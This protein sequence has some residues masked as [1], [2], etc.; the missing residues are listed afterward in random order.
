VPDRAA[1]VDDEGNGTGLKLTDDLKAPAVPEG[2]V[3]D[4]HIR[5]EPRQ[6]VRC[7]PA[8]G[9]RSCNIVPAGVERI[10]EIKPNEGTILNE[11]TEYRP[12]QSLHLPSQSEAPRSG[13]FARGH[14]G[15]IPNEV[16]ARRVEISRSPEQLRQGKACKANP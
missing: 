4:S 15:A 16:I 12:K 3:N 8:T 1:R 14:A 11:Q 13:S 6:P 9:E 10:R 7:F 5:G 2:Q